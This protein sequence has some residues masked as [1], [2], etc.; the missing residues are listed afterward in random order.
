MTNTDYSEFEEKLGYKFKDISLLETAFTHTT[1]VFEKGRSHYDSNQRLEFIGDA[2]L[3]VVVGRIIYDM[4]PFEGE[5]YLSKMRAI[6]VCERSFAAVSREL[7]IGKYL[8]LGKGEAAQG[9]ND[10]DS[11]LADAF[12][13][14]IAAIYFD[15]GFDAA[16]KVIVN[17]LS[18]TIMRAVNGEIF[19]D[20][21]SRL[22]EIAQ[23]KNHQH[24]IR[25]DIVDERGPA[26]LKEF[27]C[28][29]YAD[30]IFLAKASGKSKKDAEQKCAEIAISE[31]EKLFNIK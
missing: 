18:D 25:F 11:T 23:Q 2:V 8:L 22:L 1:Y 15:G 27:D 19:S 16:E 26:H 29:V 12:E 13:A 6:S 17:H 10:K 20:Y 30:D 4:K 7:N 24:V 28:E 3:D 5:G 14:L 31:Y 21:K 9:G